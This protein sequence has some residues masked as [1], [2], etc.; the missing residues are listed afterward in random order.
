VIETTILA[1][2]V[3]QVAKEDAAGGCGGGGGRFEIDTDDGPVASS[4]GWGGRGE[5][6]LGAAFILVFILHAASTIISNYHSLWVAC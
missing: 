1:P 3:S 6:D 2:S 5:T 4:G